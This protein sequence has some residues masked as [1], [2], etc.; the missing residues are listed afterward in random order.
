[1][2]RRSEKIGGIQPLVLERA[3]GRGWLAVSPKN[4]PLRIGVEDGT[5]DGALRKFELAIERWRLLLT[6]PS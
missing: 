6:D 4:A 5:R 3:G 2:D 1:M